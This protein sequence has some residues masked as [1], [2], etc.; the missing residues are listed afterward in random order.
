M[1][2][3]RASLMEVV[4]AACVLLSVFPC[5]GVCFS[6]GASVSSCESMSPGHIST[7]PQHTHSHTHLQ[8]AVSIRSSRS[9]YLPEHTLTVTVQSSRLFMG[10][11]LQ[12]RS[13]LHDRVLSGHFTL[14]SPGTRSLSCLHPHDSVTHSHKMLKRS[15]SFSWRAPA[16]PSGDLR[17]YITLVQS[18]F[19]YW[20]RI[21]SAVVHDGTRRSQITESDAEEAV[22][23]TPEELNRSRLQLKKQQGALVPRSNLH[24]VSTNSPFRQPKDTPGAPERGGNPPEL[25][26]GHSALELGLLLGLSAA[27]GTAVVMGLRYLQRKHCHKRSAVSLNHRDWEHRGVIHVQ[28]CGD[29]VQVRRIRENSFLVLQSEYNLITPKGN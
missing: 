7:F 12:A 24:L 18:Y 17:F 2:M 25:E 11:L 27:L 4:M 13:V 20:S 8:S 22:V 14:L 1:R 23:T 26:P 5:S 9:V 16:Q 28:E 15:M 29:L 10:F 19:V 21:R 3:R 6:R